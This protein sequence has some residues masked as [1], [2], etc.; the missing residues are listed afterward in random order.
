ML[1]FTSIFINAQEIS[2]WQPLA[3][4]LFS[5]FK[6]IQ[7]I[8]SDS[9]FISG[10]QVI[11][12]KGDIC[13]KFP[14]QPPCEISAMSAVSS[15]CIFV[16]N[17]TSYQNSDLYHWNGKK[18]QQIYN[19]MANNISDM[20]FTDSKNGLLV[21]YGEIAQ[22]INGNWYPI[23]PPNNRGIHKVTQTKEKELVVLTA[24][25]GIYIKR[26]NKW[27][28]IKHSQNTRHLSK[29]KGKIF[30]TGYNFLGVI[31]SDS[32]K[33]LS[34]DSIWSSILSISQT[35]K[36]TL[37]GVGLQ[38]KIVE[39]SKGELSTIESS[40]KQDLKQIINHNNQL[41]CIGNEGTLLI[42]SDKK[43][44]GEPITWKGF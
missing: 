1:V 30:T 20:F 2:K 41:W 21:S 7:F 13:K 24:G 19:P 42:N 4:P 37:I 9:A 29:I 26:M 28:A 17:N 18:W 15:D 38:G 11:V 5:D 3:S 33:I 44:V 25:K 39:F 31:Q 23:K 36:G 34:K 8:S 6:E 12:L 10:K 40:T 35:E 14:Q 22:M 43:K 32:L 16:S 27:I